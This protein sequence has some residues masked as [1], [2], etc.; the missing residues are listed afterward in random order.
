MAERKGMVKAEIFFKLENVYI[1][2]L[3][4]LPRREEK[5]MRRERKGIMAGAMFLSRGARMGSNVQMES[6]K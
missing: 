2:I 6:T 1:Y 4:G 3:M 5:V